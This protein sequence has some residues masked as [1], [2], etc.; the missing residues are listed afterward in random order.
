MIKSIKIT[1]FC[2]IGTTQEISF[3]IF[4]K[5]VLDNSAA[6]IVGHNINLVNCFIGHNASGKTNVLKAIAFLFWL[7]RDAYTSMKA[8]DPLPAHSHQFLTKKLTEIEIEF[9][10]NEKLFQYKVALNRHHIHKEFLGEKITRSYTKIFEYTRSSEDWNFKAP[11]LKINKNDLQRFKERKNIS[12]LSSLIATGYLPQL[13]FIKNTTAN[14]TYIGNFAPH[15]M[16]SFFNI[17]E[18]LY[19]NV[20]LKEETLAF[21]KD[22]DIGVSNFDFIEASLRMKEGK[23]IDDNEKK[24]LLSCIHESEVGKFQLPLIEESNGTRL[25]LKLLAEIIPI[26]KTGGMAIL[27]EIESGLHPYVAKKIISFFENKET[28]LHHA[29]LI[30]STHQHLLLNDRTKTQIF[31]AEK[32]NKKFETEVFR[33]DDVEGIRNDEN[34]CNKYLAGSYGGVPHINWARS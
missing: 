32:D 7:M 29:Q 33:L 21:I 27:D 20:E 26:L 34:Y 4:D 8:D 9:F 30:F 3:E 18:F 6:N 15:P 25:G 5:D 31:I 11:K 14:V 28:N 2:S 16:T 17:S 1:N 19:K 13:S 23:K 24:Y 10:N 22:I 12:V